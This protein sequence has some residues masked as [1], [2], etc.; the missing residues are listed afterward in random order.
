MAT[1]GNNVSLKLSMTDGVSSKLE[2]IT[3]NM[4]NVIKSAQSYNAILEK[5]AKNSN[6]INTNIGRFPSV[7]GLMAPTTRGSKSSTTNPEMVGI[8]RAIGTTNTA[9]NGLLITQKKLNAEFNKMP[10]FINLDTSVMQTNLGKVTTSLNNVLKAQ[11][12]LVTSAHS[13]GLNTMS[14]ETLTAMRATENAI[15]S[16]T[17]AY[18]RFEDA[19][20]KG[21]NPNVGE[22]KTAYTELASALTNVKTLQSQINNV[23]KT[24]KLPTA[25]VEKLKTVYKSLDD[26]VNKLTTDQM[27][28]SR[29]TNKSISNPKLFSYTTAEVR[30]LDNAIDA[31][32]NTHNNLQKETN[33]STSA[34]NKFN[35]E[36]TK[37]NKNT[38]STSENLSSF[39]STLMRL[40]GAYVG[41]QTLKTA[42]D[43]SD[44]LTLTE[45]KLAQLTD[46]VE[47]FMN[48]TYQMSQDTRTSYMDNAAQMAKMWQLT[49]GTN[50]I[51][52]TEDKLIEFNELLN[53]GFILGGS[54]TR[55]I[56]ASMYQLTQALSSGRLQGDELRSLAENAPYLINTIVDSIEEMYNAGKSQEEWIDLT[57]ND[58]KNL[59][60]EGVLTSELITNAVLNSADEIRDA[61]E[62]ITPTWEQT[63]QTL[64]NQVQR[65][66]QPILRTLNELINSEA[67]E[68]TT[69]AL[70]KMF[71]VAMGVLNPILQGVM[72]IG[73]FISDNW[74]IIEPMIWGIVGALTAYYVIL[75]MVKVATWLYTTATTVAKVI[76]ALYAGI[77]T[78]ITIVKGA[79]TG[80]NTAAASSAMVFIGAELGLSAATM[81]LIS[82]LL[83][84]IGIILAIVAVIYAVVWAYN[85]WTGSTLSA[86]GV[87]VGAFYWLWA[88]IKNVF[89]WIWNL[90][91]DV[92][93]WLVNKWD[94]GLYYLK[95]GIGKFGVAALKVFRLVASGIEAFVN[96]FIDGINAMISAYNMIP[97]VNNIDQVG[98]VDFTSGIDDGIENINAWIGSKP[99]EGTA[100]FSKYQYELEDLNEAYDKGYEKGAGW[101]QDIG[102]M[103]DTSKYLDGIDTNLDVG[104]YSSSIPGM[105]EYLDSIPD[106]DAPDV[107]GSTDLPDDLLNAIDDIKGNTDDIADMGEEELK[108]LKDIAEQKVINRFTTAEIKVTNNMNNNISSD[109]DIDGMADYFAEVI[110]K[111]CET[112]AERVN[113]TG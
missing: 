33:E 61:Y 37:T 85:E 77:V 71:S 76:T 31:L 16:V 45:G 57:F 101:E 95:L 59:G 96:F 26:A 21:K 49:G 112:T 38:K 18:K 22:L 9:I 51:F 68:K 19:R 41:I 99:A 67:F 60:A 97:F 24:A 83:I 54:G 66:S 94:V 28:L 86:L 81:T 100:D 8:Q 36:L 65:V 89:K 40:G 48:K 75:G 14:N 111:A 108:Y 104:D 2:R 32:I 5:I 102:E 43:W 4:N 7:S 50:G 87:I 11:D 34:T 72:A 20:A 10:N 27:E 69:Q 79:L 88:A 1:G 13:M 82:T 56:N 62:N 12:E 64:K 23:M 92:I 42:F 58:L 6:L 78:T 105:D 70:I 84:V 3:K 106:Y 73:E 74:N 63:F 53:K 35:N 110:E 91:V 46:D 93:E 98:K 103:F 25:D 52:D 55:E 30:K 109:R 44:Q 90:G 80:A 47:G 15:D 107:G 39:N 113:T 17:M 29:A